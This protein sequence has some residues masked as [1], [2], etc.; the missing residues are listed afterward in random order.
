MCGGNRIERNL[1]VGLC[2]PLPA[3]GFHPGLGRALPTGAQAVAEQPGH[4]AFHSLE[5]GRPAWACQGQGTM[6]TV[7]GRG[8]CAVLTGRAGRSRAQRHLWLLDGSDWNKLFC[9]VTASSGGAS[10]PPSRGGL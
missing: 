10:Q 5:P 7:F 6:K 3:Q 2:L 4:G 1:A 8:P 9:C